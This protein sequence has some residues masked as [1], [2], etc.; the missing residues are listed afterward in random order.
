MAESV[1]WGSI[2]TIIYGDSIPISGTITIT[3]PTST[4]TQY[5]L[6]I[7]GPGS[8]IVY[9]STGSLTSPGSTPFSAYV[10]SNSLPFPGGSY[11]YTVLM[12]IWNATYSYWSGIGTRTFTVREAVIP[13]PPTITSPSN[14][15]QFYS[16][17]L[18]PMQWTFNAQS[19]ASTQVGAEIAYTTGASGYATIAA[20]DGNDTD[21]GLSAA[22]LPLGGAKVVYFNLYMRVVSTDGLWSGWSAP[23]T[24]V[25]STAEPE[26]PAPSAP[27]NNATS[28]PLAQLL[29]TIPF[30]AIGGV[31]ASSIDF[32]YR[33]DAGA[34]WT[35]I[36]QYVVS[37]STL[38]MT[39]PANTFALG[40][41][42]WRARITDAQGITSEWSDIRTLHV[43]SSA[44]LV[45]TLT[46]PAAG[47]TQYN[48]QPVT[49]TW[50][51]NTNVDLRQFAFRMQWRISGA[52]SWTTVEQVTQTTNHIIDHGA[53]AATI[54]WR[55]QTSNEYNE[56]SA[57]SPISSYALAAPTPTAAV[58][59]PTGGFIDP[60][61]A[62][63]FEWSYTSPISSPQVDAQMQY[64]LETDANWVNVPAGNAIS[65]TIPAET[66]PLGRLLWR[67][68]V[69]DS[70][71]RWSLWSEE[72]L[73]YTRDIP[74]GEPTPLTPIDVY[75]PVSN[76]IRFSWRHN[77]PIATPQG[78]A[79]IEY[80]LDG[81][82]AV[83]AHIN[84]NVQNF[85]AMPFAIAPGTVAWRVRTYNTE[86]EP[87]PW[88]IESM[89]SVTGA[90]VAPT[91]LTSSANGSRP[92]MT[93]VAPGQIVYQV[94]LRD[95]Q[96]AL[97]DRVELPS[98]D[99]QGAYMAP[100]HVP[101][102]TYTMRVRA[103]NRYNFWSE[104]VQVS[105]T[106]NM[107][108]RLGPDI[109]ATISGS[110]VRI[111]LNGI[112][113]GASSLVLIYRDGVPVLRGRENFYLDF[114]APTNVRLRYLARVVLNDGT[115]IDSDER[116][117][118]LTAAESLIAS[119]DDLSNAIPVLIN[120][121]GAPEISMA[122]TRESVLFPV[123]GRALPMVEY[124]EH[125]TQTF[126]LTFAVLGGV[127]RE[128]MTGLFR[129]AKPVLLR[130]L[131]GRRAWCR[132]AS[133][134]DRSA[135][136]RLHAKVRSVSMTLEQVDYN[137]R[138]PID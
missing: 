42:Q 77:S 108:F 137:E 34:S 62:Q 41:V 112:D 96:G 44:P 123:A 29:V 65:V 11:T 64:K 22:L 13:N 20:I 61:R 94:E 120:L 31:A 81:S 10:S 57:Y 32:Q 110:A 51:Y 82:P 78:G 86:N 1:S 99:D 116:L 131:F 91:I 89:F 35:N 25:V 66:L 28:Y 128:K 38:S 14:N 134:S 93:W 121:D 87:G 129:Q 58:V 15:A 53:T 67:V 88:S 71:D 122:G 21:Y 3:S 117:I 37:G 109:S 33:Y 119:A 59:A 9:E 83:L 124:G 27:A 63:L 2:S 133:V 17:A 26:K 73:V 40:V 24:V 6:N 4:F 30:A 18:I 47:S 72:T 79:D 76:A 16:N 70:D 85:D 74:P 46:Q 136:T 54:E 127:D 80:S 45:P 126:S 135:L 23:V 19:G 98:L 132:V 60:I 7:T 100:M 52:G 138:V 55:V 90:P 102:D 49:Y 113:W 48:H 5:K 97:L 107:P 105:V 36:S 111:D 43:V 68:R 8:T 104:W 84:G 103:K 56:W 106:V 69:Q 118:V 92:G 114:A 130:E 39:I 95:G 115:Y 50:T 101:N 125:V 12:S 75:I